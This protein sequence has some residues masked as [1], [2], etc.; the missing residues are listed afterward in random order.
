MLLDI[1]LILRKHEVQVCLKFLERNG[2]AFLVY[3]EGLL[4]FVLEALVGQMDPQIL[5]V[6]LVLTAGS[7]EI[8]FIEKVQ[9]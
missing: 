2:V 8:A 9:I 5:I 7:S 3:G 6:F 4:A 1:H